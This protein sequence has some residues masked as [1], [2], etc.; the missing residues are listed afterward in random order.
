MATMR[1]TQKERE[2]RAVEADVERRVALWAG[3]KVRK[4]SFCR[5]FLYSNDHFTKT[6]SGQTS[7]KAHNG[8]FSWKDL[9]GLLAS[10]PAIWSGAPTADTH[11]SNTITM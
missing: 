5:L 2:V 3:R 6:G 8:A 10:L 7:E 4:R 9:R 1:A 11:F